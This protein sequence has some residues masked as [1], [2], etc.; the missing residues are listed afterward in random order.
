[1]VAALEHLCDLLFEVSNEDRLRI[2]RRLERGATSVTGLSKELELTT[3][4]SSRHLSRLG[5]VGLTSK[6]P[7]GNHSLTPFGRL[8]LEQLQGLEF[9][10]GHRDYFVSHSLAGL[11][12]EFV[13]RMGELGRSAYIDDVMVTVHNVEKILREADEYVLDLNMPF[14][15]S[16][17]PLIREAYG[18]GVVGRFLHTQELKLPPSMEDERMQFM[19]ED[20][21]QKIMASG[22]QEERLTEEV[23]LVLYMS[24][25]E[26]AIIAFPT[27]SGRFDLLGFSSD[28]ERTHRYCRDIFDHYWE[29]GR[30]LV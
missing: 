1:M 25:R 20:W 15:A 16:A 22:V 11:P 13:G 5:E 26:V 3:Q 17:F 6:D 23:G 21:I 7:D 2:M 9:T 8:I 12:P 28:D 24:E 30:P 29:R 10:S 18:R 27:V 4:E 19:D 14:V